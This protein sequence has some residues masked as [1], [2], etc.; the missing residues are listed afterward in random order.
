MS[1]ATG[2]TG[3]Q[4]LTG[5]TGTQELTGPTGPNDIDPLLRTLFP[6]VATGPV[7]PPC[8]ATLDELMASREV[9]LVK[10]ATDTASLS[11]L[12]SP[13]RET[14]RTP[15]FQW[16]ASGFESG[17]IIF[18]LVLD[19]PNICADGEIRAIGGYILYLT[20]KSS[21]QLCENIQSMMTGIRVFH[22]FRD[23]TVRIHVTKS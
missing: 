23:N 19:T 15:L 13:T 12:T 5:P 11:V 8:I 7:E 16:A 6:S 1:D 14:F 21:E 20:G 18:T 17:Y 22:S 4:E 10:E 2:P 3:T 9:T